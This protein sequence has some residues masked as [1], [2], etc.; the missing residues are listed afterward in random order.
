MRRAIKAKYDARQQIGRETSQQPGFNPL[1]ATWRAAT[2]PEHGPVAVTHRDSARLWHAT[3][4]STGTERR[5]VGFEASCVIVPPYG[6]AMTHALRLSIC[7][8]LGTVAAQ[9]AQAESGRFSQ[10]VALGKPAIDLRVAAAIHRADGRWLTLGTQTAQ[11]NRATP[12]LVLREAG[13]EQLA[14]VAL[15]PDN[16]R[17]WTARALVDVGG[18]DVIVSGM[19]QDP[20]DFS[21]PQAVFI[22]R[23]DASLQ[24]VWSRRFEQAGSSLE[25]A[26]LRAQSNGPP[27]LVGGIRP[28][29]DGVPLDGDA[30]L[31]T[32]DPV[33]GDLV[34]MRTL[35]TPE[36][37]ER[38]ADVVPLAAGGHAVLLEVRRNVDAGLEAGDGIVALGT[39]GAVASSR[40]AGHPVSAGIRASALRLI[41]DGEGFVVAGRRTAFGPNFFYLHRLAADLSPMPTRTLI[42][43]FN[44]ADVAPAPGG[45]IL[46]HGE[47]NGE[48]GDRG[49]IMMRLDARLDIT[50]QR[51]Y[52]T[53]NQ[54]FPSG[55]IAYGDGGL[56]LALGAM[57]DDDARV[58]ESVNRVDA[59]DG[60]GLLCAENTYTGFHTAIDK[61]VTSLTWAPNTAAVSFTTTP[62]AAITQ[63]LSRTTIDECATQDDLVYRDGFGA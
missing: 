41:D 61:Q 63:S 20:D 5:N 57:R 17:S 31:A 11:D 38:G 62:V 15:L 44:V 27:I 50:L 46:L 37:H 32:L 59:N 29:V 21:A 49:T 7:L 10:G 33:T 43:F 42:P 28:V 25:D 26:L 56:L 47:A 16:G 24:V 19:D 34:Q 13:G 52:G 12:Y 6:I 48:V 39:G 55:A 3:A 8:A 4:Q 54:V 36:A 9:S 30:F 1:T 22:V 53:Q 14:A 58:F 51:Q 60:E 18:G 45:G 2:L 23:L 35:G 40:L